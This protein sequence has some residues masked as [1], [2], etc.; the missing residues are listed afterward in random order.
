MNVSEFENKININSIILIKGQEYKIREI[1][2]FRVD[3]G[4]SY[5]KCYLENDFI[6]AADSSANNYFLMK[7]VSQNFPFPYAD[8]LVFDNKKFKFLFEAHAVAEE[9]FGEDTFFKVGEG[10]KFWDYSGPDGYYFSLGINDVD[11][12]KADHYGIIIK[13]EEL[14]IH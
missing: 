11:G 10:E 12:H 3:D 14:K 13:P 9:I 5:L 7:P 2:K 4:S 8:E 1:I 6:L